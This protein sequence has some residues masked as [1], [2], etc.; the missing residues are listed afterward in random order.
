MTG[1]YQTSP[2]SIFSLPNQPI[3]LQKKK[4]SPHS[5]FS[6][7]PKELTLNCC[8]SHSLNSTLITVLWWHGHMPVFHMEN[9]HWHFK[10][11]MAMHYIKVGICLFIF[12]RQ[13]K[14]FLLS[15]PTRL[16]YPFSQLSLQVSTPTNLWVRG[17]SP[18]WGFHTLLE[19]GVCNIF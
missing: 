15:V 6:K 8:R 9:K 1:K 18:V 4:K 7:K 11:F 12:T 3:F 5:F 14:L 19:Q 17:L 16:G 2:K 10:C 13:A